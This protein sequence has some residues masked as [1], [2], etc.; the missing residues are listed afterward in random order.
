MLRESF[1][2]PYAE[3]RSLGYNN[4]YYV[5]TTANLRIYHLYI[6]GEFDQ[7]T[8]NAKLKALAGI[9]FKP[10]LEQNGTQFRVIAYSYGRNDVALNSKNKIEQAKL[11]PAEVVSRRENVTLHQ[12]RIGTYA[13]RAEAVKVMESLRQK[14]LAPALVE[15]K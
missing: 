7:A 15:E 2:V 14:G 11:G 5:D 8:A 4:I 9:G 6:K 1:E 10:R 12:M 3:V 13:A